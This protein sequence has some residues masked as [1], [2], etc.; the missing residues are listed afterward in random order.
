MNRRCVWQAN[1]IAI[2]VAA[3]VTAV[4]PGCGVGEEGNT[5]SPEVVESVVAAV[6]IGQ[7]GHNLDYFPCATEGQTCVLGSGRYV[8]FGA[9]GRFVFKNLQGSSACVISTFG[10][11]PAPG[12]AKSCL[13]AN[14]RQVLS[15][16]Q[17]ATI[18][19]AENVAYGANGTF[20]FRTVSGTF[21]CD[22][23]TFGD[24]IP[25]QVKSCYLPLPDYSPAVNEGSPLAGLNMTAMAYGANGKFV[26]KILSGT[27]TCTVATFGSDPAPGVGKTCYALVAPR[28]ADEGGVY[29]TSGPAIVLY[30][31]GLNGNFIASS[32]LNAACSNATFGGDPDFG[33]GKHCYRR[34]VIP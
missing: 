2:V 23:A 11:D 5:S 25:G 32:Q 19:P 30:G 18:A 9:N 6:Q 3:T 34:T 16:N 1:G 17:Q 33:F 14:Y 20:N 31:S 7:T 29:A 12:V 24:P 26:F 15:E 27:I 22:N 28:I 21:R 4:I 10:V 8:A 13:F